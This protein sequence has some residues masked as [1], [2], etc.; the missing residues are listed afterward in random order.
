MWDGG[1]REGSDDLAAVGVADR[2]EREEL[3]RIYVASSWRNTYQPG[4]VALVREMGHEVYDFRNPH[5]GPGERGVGFQWSEIDPD[6]ESWT[7][8]QYRDALHH[9]RAQDG[10]AA[11]LAGMTWADTCVLVLPS[12]RSSHSEAGWMAGR[13]KRVIVYVPELPAP[14]LM[15]LLFDE[16]VMPPELVGALGAP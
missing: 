6:W 8:Y 12:G 3:V 15:Y 14:E 2:G 7:P 9:Q 11:D 4:V 5:L 16:I 1:A 13:G 10:Y